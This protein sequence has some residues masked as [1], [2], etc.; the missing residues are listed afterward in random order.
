MFPSV[1]VPILTALTLSGTANAWFRVGCGDPLVQVRVDPIISPNI[2]PSNHVHTVHGAS[3]FNANS[4]FDSLRASRCTSCKVTQDL[5]N[6]W[7]PKLYFQDPQTKLFEPVSNG[8]LLV[9]Y[10]NRG[11]GDVVNGGPGLK[12]FPP[13][14][15]MLTGNPTARS[16][17]YPDLEGSQGELRERA[18]GYSC[19]R[20]PNDAGY[21]GYGFP[22]TDCEGGLNARLHMPACWNGVDLDSPD[23][24]S[25]T[26]YLSGLD[27]GK[28]PSTH[29]VPLMKLFYEITWDVHDFASR[30]TPGTDEWPFVYATGDPTG[31]SWHGDFQN[32]WDT[33]V[34]QNAIDK[35]NN[36]NDA[37]G[38]GSTEACPFLTVVDAS[39]ANACKIAPV[40]DEP[41]DGQLQ[42]LPGCNPIQTGPGDATLYSSSNCPI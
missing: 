39:V 33:N 28:C 32:G 1:F 30:W 13:G 14:F 27:N 9:Y 6:Y 24:M 18:V 41:I 23:H 17:K 4:T 22:N 29:P 42:R 40:V 37:T 7:F 34:F 31:Y 35:C 12:A 11:D 36:P 21:D 5:S 25:H 20:Y 26:A 3:N 15:K 19:L 16:K 10:Q 2:I 8:G 38:S